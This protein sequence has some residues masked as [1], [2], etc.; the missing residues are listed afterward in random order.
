MR[1]FGED[2]VGVMIAV[3]SGEDENSKF[4][5]LRLAVDGI[6]RER[7]FDARPSTV[8]TGV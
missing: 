1:Q 3:R 7:E 5:T 2:V 4:H 8:K 6:W